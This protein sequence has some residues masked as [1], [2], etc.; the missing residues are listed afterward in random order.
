M[1]VN[2]CVVVA[3]AVGARLLLAK[4]DVDGNVKL[5]ESAL[6]QN[7]KNPAH[8]ESKARFANEIARQIASTVAGWTSGSVLVAA[9]PDL[10]TLL[11]ELIQASLPQGVT[12]RSLARDHVGLS[13]EEL[14]G[15]LDLS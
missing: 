13:P 5:M 2:C 12:L 1:R 10:L 14:A 15:R 8:V 3:D 7:R 4:R 6:L 9:E 11:R